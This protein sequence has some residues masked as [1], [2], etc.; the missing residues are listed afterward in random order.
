[1]KLGIPFADSVVKS[2]ETLSCVGDIGRDKD[3]F[4]ELHRDRSALLNVFRAKVK[5]DAYW[6]HL[7]ENCRP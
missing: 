3:E 6:A 2:F 7:R 1:M 5:L 4:L